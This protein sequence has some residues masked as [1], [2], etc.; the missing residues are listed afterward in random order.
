MESQPDPPPPARSTPVSPARTEDGAPAAQVSLRRIAPSAFGP[1]LVFEIGQGAAAPVVALAARDL[2]ASVGTA[3]L[4]V[5]LLGVGRIA[6]TLPAG[7]LAARF[8]ERRAM[9]GAALVAAAAV[10]GCALAG[11]VGLLAVCVA[12]YGMCEATFALARQSY[13]TEVVPARLRARA[14]STLGGVA[15]IGVFLGPFAGALVLAGGD[16]RSAFWVSLA[17]SLAAAV[18]V[19]VVRPLPPPATPTPAGDAAE[20]GAGGGDGDGGGG[21]AGSEPTLRSVLWSYRRVLATL[22]VAVVM[23]GAVRA[24]R[25]AVL[26]LWADQ[27]QVDAATVSVVFGVSAAVDM[28]LFYPAGYLMDRFGRLAVG[29]PSMLLLGAGHALLPLTDSLTGLAVVAMLL[30]FGNGMGSGL[31]MTIGA[32]VSPRRGRAAFLSAWRLCADSGNALGPLL[33]SAAAAAGSLT[34]GVLGMA[35][36]GLVAAGALAVSL[37]RVRLRAP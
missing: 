25:Q 22:G 30:G 6:G 1:T 5:V 23:V 34:A 26:P 20:P 24:S 13:L 15:R 10:A 2:G 11:R 16:V 29:V 36:V 19:L 12:V 7:V 21:G 33:V 18:V 8:G 35:G 37:R 4:V 3:G 28:L 17:A 31:L 9:L 14:M 32:D 27:M